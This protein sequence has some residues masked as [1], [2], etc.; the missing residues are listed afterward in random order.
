MN[1]HTQVCYDL[2]PSGEFNSAPHG[3]EQPVSEFERGVQPEGASGGALGDLCSVSVSPAVPHL[4]S[5]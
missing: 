4:C 1:W 2:I 5:S 3:V